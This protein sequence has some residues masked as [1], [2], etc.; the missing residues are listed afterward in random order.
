MSAADPFVAIALARGLDALLALPLVAGLWWLTRRRATPHFRALLPWLALLP[1]VVPWSAIVPEPLRA[2]S[3][4]NWVV[5]GG[6]HFA[7]SPATPHDLPVE[8]A[9]RAIGAELDELLAAALHGERTQPVAPITASESA[10][11]AA[12]SLAVRGPS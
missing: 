6:P 2:W 10:G 7:A 5:G 4:R 3:W 8:R 9:H 12:T 11:S 1:L